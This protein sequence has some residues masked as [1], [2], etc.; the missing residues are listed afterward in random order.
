[1]RFP[2]LSIRAKLAIGFGA[3][4]VLILAM[5]AAAIF[6]FS[7]FQ[8]ANELNTLSY[9]TMEE[10]HGLLE[11]LNGIQTGERGFA[12]TGMEGYLA[13]A[14]RGKSSFDRRMARAMQ[15]T[16]ANAEQQGRLQQLEQA[17]KQWL[18]L[19]IEPVLKMRKGVTAGAIQMDSLV[20]FEQ[21]G[22]GEELM[23][24]MRKMLDEINAVEAASRET[25]SREADVLQ[26][27]TEVILIGGGVLVA[28]MASIIAMVLIRSIVK[29]LAQAV[30]VAETVAAG[31]LSSHIEVGTGGETGQLLSALKNMHDGLEDIVERVRT[32]TDAIS[33]AAT[34]IADG[35]SNLSARTETQS[36]SLEKTSAA[37]GVLTEAVHKNADNAQQ[38]NT[39]ASSACGQAR[40]AGD[41]VRKVVDNMASIRD[42]SRKITD[43][44]AVIDGIAFQ[45]NILA[46]NAAVE[47]ARAGEQ[48]R[49]FAVVAA[50]V[51]NLSQ[52]SVTAAKEIKALITDSVSNVDAGSALVDE[53]G[54]VMGE[55]VSSV[56][57][58]AGI[59]GD[60]ASASEEQRSGIDNVR[61][62]IG[63][64][65]GM[66]Q[67]NAALVEEAAAAAMSMRE[68]AATLSAAVRAF[69]L[70][71]DAG[72]EGGGSREGL[73]P[74]EAPARIL[75]GMPE[76]EAARPAAM[77][78][79]VGRG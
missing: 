18:K 59:M 60:I 3:I 77:L 27:A 45:T 20:Q 2:R 12:L 43:I 69:T 65:D 23:T 31:D 24:D 52:R 41:V 32:G 34:E 25:R 58:V 50:E 5:L 44:I 7:R 64:M 14:E 68:Q 39:L 46:L 53:A 67:Q 17:E 33:I 28:A 21:G 6:N 47:A 42:S 54:K 71:G 79:L 10:T 8:R 51:R 70:S 61:Q 78:R 38:A 36:T 48:G 19:A 13:P 16:A 73:A 26:G 49:G 74:G 4:V 29:P 76:P 57:H 75:R 15:L 37:I 66:T 1:M 55:V 9:R 30:R 22:R 56:M 11:S 62:A 35:N 63:M 40:N 72:A